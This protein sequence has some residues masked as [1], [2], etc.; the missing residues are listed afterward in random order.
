MAWEWSAVEETVRTKAAGG[1]AWPAVGALA[2]T[3]LLT[4]PRR[5]SH[6]ALGWR[7]PALAHLSILWELARN[8]DSQARPQNTGSTGM[9]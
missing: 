5:L 3:R 7:S 4:G 9:D 2:T 8:A 6:L 1:Q